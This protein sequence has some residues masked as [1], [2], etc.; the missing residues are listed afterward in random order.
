MSNFA[1]S[2]DETL[3]LHY[4]ECMICDEKLCCESYL[5]IKQAFYPAA[6]K[7]HSCRGRDA[8]NTICKIQNTKN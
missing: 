1:I 7:L 4:Y 8:K 5:G 2:C 6:D 3:V